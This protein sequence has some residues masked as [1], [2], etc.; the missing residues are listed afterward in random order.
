M[1]AQQKVEAAEYA[2]YWPREGFCRICQ[3]MIYG[4]AAKAGLPEDP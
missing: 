4:G 2:E 1:E 3:R